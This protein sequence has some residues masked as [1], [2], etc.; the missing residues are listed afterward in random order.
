MALVDVLEITDDKYEKKEKVKEV[1]RKAADA[2]LNFQDKENVIIATNDQFKMFGFSINLDYLPNSRVKFRT[3]ARYFKSKNDV[4]EKNSD[5]VN[6]NLFLKT[7]L[8][9]EF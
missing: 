9:F 8:S 2:L 6:S 1:F 7:S 4:F 3:E 5:L